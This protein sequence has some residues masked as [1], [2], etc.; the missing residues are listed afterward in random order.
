MPSSDKDYVDINWL[1]AQM[2]MNPQRVEFLARKYGAYKR[3]PTSPGAIHL[4]KFIS[5][6]VADPDVVV[7]RRL[8]LCPSCRFRT[9]IS[10][11]GLA[12]YRGPI[13]GETNLIRNGG[14]RRGDDPEKC[15]KYEE[16]E[17]KQ[18]KFNLMGDFL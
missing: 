5:A 18:S 9:E 17:K 2:K 13:A 10:G 15:L 16:G 4:K 1:G 6:A 7:P 3:K 8:T 14:D 12:C 11:T